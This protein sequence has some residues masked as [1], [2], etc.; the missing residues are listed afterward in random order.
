MGR[1]EKK[2]QRDK[3]DRAYKIVSILT[4]IVEILLALREIL[5]G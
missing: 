2:P 3:L 1:H 4:G 5:K